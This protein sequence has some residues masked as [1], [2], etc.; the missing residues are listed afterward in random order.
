MRTAWFLPLALCGSLIAQDT[1]ARFGLKAEG[2]KTWE[3]FIG[4]LA[5]RGGPVFL[6][7]GTEQKEMAWVDLLQDEALA[8]MGLEPM[9]LT[10]KDPLTVELRRRFG[11]DALPRWAAM[12]DQGALLISE[13][14]LP[15][16]GTALAGKLLAGGFEGRLQVLEAFLRRHP[17]HGEAHE[18]LVTA[19]FDLALRRYRGW[20]ERNRAAA[21]PLSE[22]EDA[23]MF[24]AFC[25]ALDRLL[26]LPDW[27]SCIPVPV[28]FPTGLPRP[29]SGL[30]ATSARRHLPAVE[31]QLRR[32]PRSS[33]PWHLWLFLADAAGGR[34]LLPLLDSIE[35]RPDLLGFPSNVPIKRLAEELRSTKAWQRLVDGFTPI[36][37]RYL[38]QPAILFS[39]GEGPEAAWEDQL[40]P[41]LEGQLRLGLQ[42]PADELVRRALEATKW[43]G[44]PA[45][46]GA[47]ARACG[48]PQL[49]QLWEALPVPEAKR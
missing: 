28:R 35:P 39:L 10:V 32:T 38:S 45:K 14:G 5:R 31:A 12:S 9:R 17:D 3:A 33:R 20:R 13:P 47:L 42:T 24:R 26:A 48:H 15:T 22:A 18:A 44:L 1:F 43:S 34:P 49:A 36:S 11:W 46:A 6:L 23:R 30:L 19:R 41:L 16:S 27:S 29:G 40:A 4:G 7:I 2:D 37:E 8:E 21:G 25:H